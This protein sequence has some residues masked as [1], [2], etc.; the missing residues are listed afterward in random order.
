[1]AFYIELGTLL[2]AIL[3]IALILRI[4]KEPGPIIWNS[5]A[6]IISFFILNWVFH[7]GIPIN[8]WSIAIVALG[9]VGGLILVLLLHFLGLGF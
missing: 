3:I 1:M 2:L 9:G 5:I 6:G 8:I 7:L 4:F